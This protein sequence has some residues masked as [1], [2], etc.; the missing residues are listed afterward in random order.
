MINSAGAGYLRR[1]VQEVI[2]RTDD[3]LFAPEM[4]RTIR[5]R[6]R[7][8]VAS[9]ETRTDEYAEFVDGQRRTFLAIKGPCRDAQ[10]RITG[11]FGIS[12]DISDRKLER[13]LFTGILQGS[14][15][16][17]SAID[18]DFRF[19]A[20]NAALQREYKEG[21]GAELTRGARISDVL[22]DHPE[23][24]ARRL[25]VLGRALR[26]E[27]SQEVWT[28]GE[29][30]RGS[31]WYDVRVTPIRDETGHVIGGSIIG[32]DITKQREAESRLRRSEARFRALGLQA[33]VGIFETDRCGQCTFVNTRW[34]ELTGLAMEEALGRVWSEAVHPDDLA[35]VAFA[36]DQ[37]IER[38]GEFHADYR[39]QRADTEDV[40]VSAAAAPLV[41]A[42]GE[43]G[44]WLGTVMDVTERR[45][46]EEEIRSN[47]D[48]IRLLNDR[49]AS[50]AHALEA[51]NREL[52][53]FSY[54]VSHDLR[55]PLRAIDGFTRALDEDY[56]AQLDAKAHDYMD[57]VRRATRR[58]GQIIDDLLLL[59]RL[60]R[61]ELRSERVDLTALAGEVDA[62]LRGSQPGRDVAFSVAPGLCAT[63]DSR[64]LRLVLENLLGNAW[65]Y[66]SRQP[67]AQ[68]AFGMEN[69]AG[70]RVFYVRDDGA[71]F[72][73]AYAGKLFGAFQRL[74]NADEFPG[75]GIGLATVAR[76]VQRHGGRTWAEGAVGQGATFYFT[77]GKGADS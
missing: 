56:G 23:D 68:I 54:S 49:L 6:D 18:R 58:M 59:S 17:V 42:V 33:P 19:V 35:R 60:A 28:V 31:R 66:T 32:R 75:S 4:A 9:G 12:R 25:S 64:L 73:M 1:P 22:A 5:E 67:R 14:H 46:T 48:E 39:L 71:G 11:V 24:L 70:E 72:D 57:R 38:R 43:P 41:D 55:T 26:G 65:K 13:S 50:R 74:H 69:G 45:R 40:W 16:I 61:G 8:I 27:E 30:R 53:T 15:D 77:L 76:I 7:A 47:R 62:A 37:A 21:F 3:E 34:C 51:A 29:P 63:G 20:F 44:G 2:G 52:E 10:G 36:W